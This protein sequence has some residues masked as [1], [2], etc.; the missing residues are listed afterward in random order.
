MSKPTLRWRLHL[1]IRKAPLA[2]KYVALIVTFNSLPPG[3]SR[4][5]SIWKAKWPAPGRFTLRGLREGFKV[6][7]LELKMDHNCA[8]TTDECKGNA[9]RRDSCYDDLPWLRF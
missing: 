1:S 6:G 7:F 5:T 3:F 9:R 2:A 8:P 4:K